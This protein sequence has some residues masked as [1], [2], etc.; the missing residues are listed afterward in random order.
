[1]AAHTTFDMIKLDTNYLSDFLLHRIS[2]LYDPAERL[3]VIFFFNAAQDTT[4][5]N[6][7]YFTIAHAFEA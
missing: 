1:M 2:A 3:V 5:S 7:R 6:L 4:R